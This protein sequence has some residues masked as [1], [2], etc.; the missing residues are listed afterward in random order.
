MTPRTIE[1]AAELANRIETQLNQVLIGQPAVTRQV[2]LALITG[3]HVLI[4]GVPGLGK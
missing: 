1:E 4:E 2:M 3:G